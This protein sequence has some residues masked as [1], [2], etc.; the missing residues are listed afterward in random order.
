MA[1]DLAAWLTQI[2]DA[3]QRL[4]E[5]APDFVEEDSARGPGWGKAGGDECEVCG[6]YQFSGYESVVKEAW[7]EHME[8]HHQRRE[9][10]ARIAADRQILADWQQANGEHQ[11]W[12]EE[13]DDF[14]A[15]EDYGRADKVRGA[16]ESLERIVRILALPYA[17]RPGYREEWRPE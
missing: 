4:Y 8:R 1:D 15:I 11:S 5:H 6:D 14:G 7:Y 12:C 3:R 10:L 17:D 9:V 2:W 13:Y 16:L